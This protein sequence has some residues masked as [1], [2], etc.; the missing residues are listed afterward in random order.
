MKKLF[1]FPLIIS[2]LCGSANAQT[3]TSSTDPNSISLTDSKGI[4]YRLVSVGDMLPRLFVNDKE[5]GRELLEHYAAVT[6]KLQADLFE[7]QKKQALL[8]NRENEE[9]VNRIVNDLVS[10]KIISSPAAL[11]S[12]KLDINGFIINGQKQSY[13]LYKQYKDKFLTSADK[14][15]RF[16]SN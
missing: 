7:R 4:K 3:Q 15:Y 2:C 11:T 5:V 6:G 13:G 10:Q 12:L 9:L 8:H 1:L 14:V 16:N